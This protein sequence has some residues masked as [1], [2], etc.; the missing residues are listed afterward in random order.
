MKTQFVINALVACALPKITDQAK[1]A[2][3]CEAYLNS[4]KAVEE[5]SSRSGL[6]D[7]KKSNDSRTT[8]TLQT[9]YAG[10]RNIVSDFVGWHDKV[11]NI[12]SKATKIGCVLNVSE[13]PPRF[14]DWIA[15]FE[16]KGGQPKPKTSA[17][18]NGPT[19]KQPALAAA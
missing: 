7:I 19:P 18:A 5:K 14:A 10:E 4:M 15:K 3:A 9:T 11:V 2:Q 13:V 12:S 1:L 16:T 17:T 8:E 6:R